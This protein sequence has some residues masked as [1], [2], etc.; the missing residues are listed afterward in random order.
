MQCDGPGLVGR[1]RAALQKK[2]ETVSGDEF[3]QGHDPAT[4]AGDLQDFGQVGATVTLHGHVSL[5][6]TGKFPINIPRV[7]V[8]VPHQKY[9]AV[10]SGFQLSFRYILLS[11]E[12]KRLENNFHPK[13]YAVSILFLP[14][15]FGIIWY[16][17]QRMRVY[18]TMGM[19]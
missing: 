9:N 8:P 13:P 12:R 1:K 17:L 4:V 11:Q 14:T 6:G 19:N 7:G 16:V 15:K 3:L 10:C 5:R 2:S 18:Y